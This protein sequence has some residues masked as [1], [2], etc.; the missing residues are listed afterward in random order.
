VNR[1]TLQGLGGFFFG[2]PSCSGRAL[3]GMNITL[4]HLFFSPKKK[5]GGHFAN[6]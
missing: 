3:S 4:N 2:K 6:N 1:Q 5:M